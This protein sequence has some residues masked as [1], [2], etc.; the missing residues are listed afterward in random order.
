MV[1]V[2]IRVKLNKPGE[3]KNPQKL[4]NPV[5]YLS[6]MMSLCFFFSPFLLP[7]FSSST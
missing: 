4:N 1:K 2:I 6:E 7:A 3:T 5:E